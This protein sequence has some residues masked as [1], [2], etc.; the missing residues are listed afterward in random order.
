MY[1]GESAY[2]ITYMVK[3][4]IM[5]WRHTQTNCAM[6][7]KVE[8]HPAPKKKTKLCATH[9]HAHKRAHYALPMLSFQGV[10]CRLTYW[11]WIFILVFLLKYWTNF[12]DDMC[13]APSSHSVTETSCGGGRQ[14][15]IPDTPNGAYQPTSIEGLCRKHN[16]TLVTREP[17]SSKL[18]KCLRT[19]AVPLTQ[20]FGELVVFLINCETASSV[21]RFHRYDQTDRTRDETFTVPTVTKNL[22][23]ATNPLCER[24]MVQCWLLATG[25]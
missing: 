20:Q 5:R 16:G 24:G 3:C 15:I 6:V 18:L 19:L 10:Q 4:I 25:L 11:A 21:C 8:P 12:S 2:G 7:D 13:F 22:V 14:F 17:A 23:F 1:M 9:A